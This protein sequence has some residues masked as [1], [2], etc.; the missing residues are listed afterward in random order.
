MYTVCS[1]DNA[2][3]NTW[4]ISSAQPDLCMLFLYTTRQWL[5]LVPRKAL[6]RTYNALSRLP[7]MTSWLPSSPYHLVPPFLVPAPSFLT[8]DLACSGIETCRCEC[9]WPAVATRPI[10]S[11]AFPNISWGKFGNFTSPALL[12]LISSAA[13]Y[14]RH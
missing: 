13:P 5:I 14:S 8:L 3:G 1:K 9:W 2:Y 4:Y 11:T 10:K 6:I 12:S 7:L